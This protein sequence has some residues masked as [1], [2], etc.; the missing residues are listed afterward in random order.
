MAP[1]SRSQS[2]LVAY[3]AVVDQALLAILRDRGLLISSYELGEAVMRVLPDPTAEARWFA[4]EDVFAGVAVDAAGLEERPLK[5]VEKFWEVLLAMARGDA[6][7]GNVPF[8][9]ALP[10][11]CFE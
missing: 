3:R 8:A 11:W 10:R 9:K 2:F 7:S 1:R 6:I 4:G 5:V